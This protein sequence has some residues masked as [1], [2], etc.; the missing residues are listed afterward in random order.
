MLG[1]LAIG[2]IVFPF[3]FEDWDPHPMWSV[4]FML[5]LL[6]ALAVHETRPYKVS[7]MHMLMSTA[8]TVRLQHAYDAQRVSQLAHLSADNQMQGS[9][10]PCKA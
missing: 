4:P 3:M 10:S 8:A 6:G 9:A 1:L 2:G 7:S 5:L